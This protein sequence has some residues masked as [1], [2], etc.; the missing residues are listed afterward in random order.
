MV[1][2]VRALTIAESGRQLQAEVVDAARMLYDGD[3]FFAAALERLRERLPRLGAR[4][5]W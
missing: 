4:R 2:R 3:G 5:I 1:E